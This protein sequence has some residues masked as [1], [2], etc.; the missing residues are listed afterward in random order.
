LRKFAVLTL[1]RVKN[2]GSVLQCY[3]TQQLIAQYCND[4]EIIDYYPYRNTFAGMLKSLFHRYDNKRFGKIISLPAIIIIL[5]SY[6][7]R[8]FVFNKFLCQYIKLSSK[9]YN[10]A[11]GITESDIAADGYIT[12]SDQVWNSSW[13]GSIDKTYFLD[14]AENKCKASFSSS[15]GKDRLTPEE[16]YAYREL[17]AKYKALSVRELSGI[18]ILSELGFPATQVLDPT[19]VIHV[20]AWKNLMTKKYRDHKYILLYNI[21][22]E[23]GLE[24]YAR[25]L[26][27]YYKLPIYRITYQ[28]HDIIKVGHIKCC[29]S[30]GDFLSLIY[31]AEY[32]IS[33]SFHML[34]FSVLFHKKFMTFYPKKFST[35]LKSLID[36]LGLQN[37]VID[38]MT[39]PEAVDSQIDFSKIDDVIEEN[40]IISN[41]FLQSVLNN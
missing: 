24:E 19:L 3:A 2:Y 10:E 14:F 25:K 36:L 17:L 34:S 38:G 6:I 26:R 40:R 27:R 15:F 32:I 28:Y 30:V 12:G 7:K 35:R 1:H 41:E 16:S 5:P 29:V 23:Y 37:R 9:K 13:F 8:F 21:N 33:D 20:T 11:S 22:R 31:N 4:F 18:T 39:T